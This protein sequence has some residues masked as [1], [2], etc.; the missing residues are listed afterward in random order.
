MSLLNGLPVPFGKEK[1]SN[2]GQGMANFLRLM[3]M[4][5]G[6]KEGAEMTKEVGARNTADAANSWIESQGFQGTEKYPNPN[7]Y[8]E[9]LRARAYANKNQNM[10]SM[11]RESGG[12]EAKAAEIIKLHPE[13]GVDPDTAPNLKRL[14]DIGSQMAGVRQKANA[15]EINT[16]ESKTKLD[17]MTFGT[18]QKAMANKALLDMSTKLGD[19]PTAQAEVA[20]ALEQSLQPDVTASMMLA[21]VARIGG[22]Y[23]SVLSPSSQVEFT[24]TD[25]GGK[26]FVV[27]QMP[28]SKAFR[29]FDT[30]ELSAVDKLQYQDA[31]SR[32]RTAEA[33]LADPLKRIG[34]GEYQKIIDDANTQIETLLGKQS[35]PAPGAT[36]ETQAVEI[37]DSQGKKW[38]YT[39]NNPDPKLDKDPT[40]WK[41]AQ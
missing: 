18:K 29:I 36:A 3:S 24:E 30:S 39:G 26:K 16:I 27:A 14:V 13:W 10:I 25:V 8:P 21:E 19:D 35:A 34:R 9:D 37:T 1:Q 15:A 2:S 33:A 38:K 7:K 12:D 32:R 31:L 41:P 20:A 22:K 23:G 6:Q 40:H 28:G 5:Q 17:A 11:L 4:I